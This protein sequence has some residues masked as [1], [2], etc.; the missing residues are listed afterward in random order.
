[1]AVELVC[2]PMKHLFAVRGVGVTGGRAIGILSEVSGHGT[3]LSI[4]AFAILASSALYQA[5]E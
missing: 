2:M 3:M 1:M 5:A 4:A